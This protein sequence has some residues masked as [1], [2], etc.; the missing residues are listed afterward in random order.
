MNDADFQLP[1]LLGP[2]ASPACKKH[3]D[4]LH[5]S[6]LCCTVRCGSNTNKAVSNEPARPRA[7]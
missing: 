6:L 3:A 1:H 7:A 2:R 4:A 5:Q